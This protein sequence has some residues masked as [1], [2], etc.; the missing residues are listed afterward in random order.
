MRAFVELRIDSRPTKYPARTP[1]RMAGTEIQ[2]RLRRWRLRSFNIACF[3][4]NLASGAPGC[5]SPV[6]I[7]S[8][9]AG[10]DCQSAP[11]FLGFTFQDFYFDPMSGPGLACSIR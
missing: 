1:S 6:S 11:G 7:Q 10:F 4:G 5:L 3:L 9:S 8:K 2:S